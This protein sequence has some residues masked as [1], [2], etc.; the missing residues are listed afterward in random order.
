MIYWVILTKYISD[1]NLYKIN[2]TLYQV[3]VKLG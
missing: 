1:L 3:I 2:T